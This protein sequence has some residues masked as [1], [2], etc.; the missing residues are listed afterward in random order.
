MERV[1]NNLLTLTRCEAGV[2]SVHWEAIDVAMMVD[3]SWRRLRKV[4]PDGECALE[5]SVSADS[6]LVSDLAK[7]R[8]IVDNLLENAVRYSP[9]GSG[10]SCSYR[11]SEGE[12]R[13]TVLNDAPNLDHEDLDHL[14]ERF[15]RKDPSRSDGKHSGLG[16]TLCQAL[17]KEM[18]YTVAAKLRGGVL[19]IALAG[20]TQ[21]P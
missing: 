13:L 7:L 20:P 4:L 14:F 19:E 21:Q 5:A 3:Q 1:I 17:A 9:E 11:A 15:W 12:F 2:E 18:G 6:T 8:M 16:L 10:V